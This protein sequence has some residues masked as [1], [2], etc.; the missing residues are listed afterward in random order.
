[1]LVIMSHASNVLSDNPSVIHSYLVLVVLDVK[2]WLVSLLSV[3]TTSCSKLKSLKVYVVGTSAST[4]YLR[5]RIVCRRPEQLTH[6]ERSLSS[7]HHVECFGTTQL[8]CLQFPEYGLPPRSGATTLI[9]EVEYFGYAIDTAP[10]SW[11]HR[12]GYWVCLYLVISMVYPQLLG[13]TKVVV[14]SP[15]ISMVS[16]VALTCCRCVEP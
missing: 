14:C 10:M 9:H 4:S 16:I 11:V 15:A 7:C 3:P 2:V 6:Q 8:T 1:M 13:T 12:C 5:S